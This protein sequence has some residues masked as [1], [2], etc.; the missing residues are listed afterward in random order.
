MKREPVWPIK[1]VLLALHEEQI[2]EHG[3]RPGLR[4]EGL[5]DSALAR[6]RQAFA[7]GAPTLLEMA[8]L[9]AVGL[10]KNHP[11]HDGNKRASLIA[12]EL[13]LELTVLRSPLRMRN[14]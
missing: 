9:L 13:F 11:F 6:P 4:D 2:A 5:L 12:T 10:C 14:S 8:A 1:S 7:Y 3:G